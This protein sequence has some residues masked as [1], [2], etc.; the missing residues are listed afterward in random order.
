MLTT[1]TPD[2]IPKS[3]RIKLLSNRCNLDHIKRTHGNIVDQLEMFLTIYSSSC[4]PFASGIVVQDSGVNGIQ[5][6]CA[7][8]TDTTFCSFLPILWFIWL[9]EVGHFG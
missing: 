6:L 3:T 1:L 2:Y 9:L 7:Y 8:V 4:P 5:Y